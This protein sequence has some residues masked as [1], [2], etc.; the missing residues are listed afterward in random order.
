MNFAHTHD[1]ATLVPDGQV[2]VANGED[3]KPR[4][5]LCNPATGTWAVTGQ[6]QRNV[7]GGRVLSLPGEPR[8]GRC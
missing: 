7:V 1:T 5:E 2:L 8:P 3:A 6:I 4:P